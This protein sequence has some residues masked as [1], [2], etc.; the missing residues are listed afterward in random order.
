MTQVEMKQ[1]LEA[2]EMT[3]KAQLAH[4]EKLGTEKGMAFEAGWY[5]GTIRQAILELQFIQTK[6]K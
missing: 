2:L 6:T 5:I 3:L 4:G 1:H